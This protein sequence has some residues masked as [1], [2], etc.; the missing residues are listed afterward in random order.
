MDDART[1]PESHAIVL[2]REWGLM[3][4]LAVLTFLVAAYFAP[5]GF[6][7]GFTD[8]AHDG[9]QLRQVLDLDRGGT[10]FKDTFDQY[11]PLAGYLNLAGYRLLGH[12]LLAVKYAHCLWYAAIAMLL[13]LLARTL[14]PPGS[15]AASVLVWLALA[16]FS[17]HGIM[18]S[19]HTYI[20]FFQVLGALA[21][22]RFGDT[23]RMRDVA[24]AGVCGGLCW[25]LKTN[26]G[27][28]FAAGAIAYLVSRSVRGVSS[29]RRG[30]AEVAALLGGALLVV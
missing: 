11:G 8:M 4:G 30:V 22:I 13:Y 27:F 25:A 24:V 3:L 26:M 7:A 14:L 5:R 16:P 23:N 10:I 20:L 21:L 6:R 29:A 9:Y 15:S 1:V 17:L 12:T 2:R 19:P 28:L 18:I